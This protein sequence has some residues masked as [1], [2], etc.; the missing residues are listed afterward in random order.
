MQKTKR[1]LNLIALIVFL[2]SNFLTP[3]SYATSDLSISWVEWNESDGSYV[4]TEQGTQDFLASTSEWQTWE[5]LEWQEDEQNDDSVS[6]W[7]EWNGSE[8]F[9]NDSETPID[10]SSNPKNDDNDGN[11][12]KPEPRDEV[13]ENSS[14]DLLKDTIDN[15]STNPDDNTE[16]TQSPENNEQDGRENENSIKNS[17]NDIPESENDETVGIESEE[18]YWTW[19][20]EWVKVEVYAATWLFESWTILTIEPVIEE[21]LEQVKEVLSWE[22]EMVDDKEDQT[23]IAFD[24]TFRNPATQEEIQPKNW[25]VQVTFNYEENENL[26]QA[27]EDEE[28]EIKVYHLND[29]DEE[30][31]KIEEITWSKVE[32]IIINKEWTEE[33]KIVVEVDNFSIYVVGNISLKSLN[34]WDLVEITYNTNWWIF[35]DWG[36]Q[37]SIQYIFHAPVWWPEYSHTP[38]ISDD[39]VQ[40]WNYN[41][42]LNTDAHV[43][44]IPWAKKL[45]ITI[46]HGTESTSYDWVSMWLWSHPYYKAGNNYSSSIIWTGWR[47]WWTT[48]TLT[49]NVYIVDWDTVTFSFK[50]DWSVNYYWYYAIIEDIWRYSTDETMENPTKEWYWFVWWAEEWSTELYDISQWLPSNNTL[51]AVRKENK[52]IKYNANGWYFKIWDTT[53]DEV[54]VGY[55]VQG[56][57]EYEPVMNLQFPNRITEDIEEQS[58]WMFA[59]WYTTEW[60][61]STQ[62]TEWLWQVT[63]STENNMVVYAKWLPFNDISIMDWEQVWFTIMDRNLWAESI[64]YW[65]DLDGMGYYYQWWNNYWFSSNSGAII[66]TSS[67][68]VDVSWYWPDNYYSSDTFITNTS[69]DLSNNKNLWWWTWD[70]LKTRWE[71]T[72][73]DRQWPCP[74]GYHI[75]SILERKFAYNVRYNSSERSTD[76]NSDLKNFIKDFQLPFAGDRSYSN[77]NVINQGTYGYYLS[78]SPLPNSVNVYYTLYMYN[79]WSFSTQYSGYPGNGYSVRC[80]K[81]L[82]KTKKIQYFT[83]TWEKITEYNLDWWN[84]IPYINSHHDERMWYEYLGWFESWSNEWF[85]FTQDVARSVSLYERRINIEWITEAD[86]AKLLNWKKFNSAIKTL[87]SWAI[88]A[89]EEF[90]YE[91]KWIE[92]SENLPQWV[93]KKLISSEDSESPIFAWYDT[94][95]QKIKY[96]TKAHEVYMNEDSSY[97]YSKLRNLNSINLEEFKTDYV[98]NMDWMFYYSCSSIDGLNL[99]FRNLNLSNVTSMANMFNSFLYQWSWANNITI[100]FSNTDLNNVTNVNQMFYYSFAYAQNVSW[101]TIDFSEADMRSVTN[102]GYMFEYSFENAQNV[103]W[104]TI[105]FSEVF[106]KQIWKVHIICLICLPI[107]LRMQKV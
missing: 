105:D 63:D 27:E 31:E 46:K 106:Q 21:K 80:F 37:K 78:S 55:L 66:K 40:N 64:S 51:Y 97:M 28:Q 71:W 24:I 77:W 23:V 88:V 82:P 14:L 7:T 101:V 20:Y 18:I 73:E 75:P 96:Y 29:K 8:E 12:E 30:W 13:I 41:N 52:N 47:L 9:S 74:V 102:M 103:S 107:I 3:I 89:Y 17:E 79:G 81:N 49:T 43:V 85:D 93:N 61:A 92:R 70:S 32:E 6:S 45:K 16:P 62:T 68:R 83:E 42:N 94:E 19:E 67:E 60:E 99:D 98:K 33:N 11:I 53:T 1:I 76:E 86:T 44:S 72:D 25:T 87:A 26:V 69:W 65:N 10:S 34:E 4:W 50:S 5:A 84:S 36:N 48:S 100:N 35:W 2:M 95:S 22:V 90:D 38:N 39:W 104:V 58:W 15:I 56:N 59:W 54:D 91:I 57:F